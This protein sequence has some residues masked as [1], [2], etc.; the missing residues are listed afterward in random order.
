[1]EMKAREEHILGVRDNNTEESTSYLNLRGQ[2]AT[3]VDL[4]A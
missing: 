3:A 2:E 4:N 1:M